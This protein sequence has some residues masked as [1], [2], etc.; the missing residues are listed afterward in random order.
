VDS[1]RVGLVGVSMG[2]YLAVAAAARPELRIACVAESFGG[3][4]PGH[5]NGLRQMP[6]TLVVHGEFDT[7]VP[8][9]EAHALSGRLRALGR[10]CE[11][12]VYPGV[13]HGFVTP[14]GGTCLVSAWDAEQCLASFLS[15]H[16]GRTAARKT[17]L[18]CSQMPPGTREN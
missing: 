6:P 4:P 7:T 8:V 2:G 18:S 12:R 13:G 5:E 16:L 14:D 1:R 9:R 10:T 17:V 15:R 3:L 11:V